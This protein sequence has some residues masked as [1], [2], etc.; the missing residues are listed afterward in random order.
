MVWIVVGAL[1]ADLM[2]QTFPE[3]SACLDAGNQTQF[4]LNMCSARGARISD[5][6]RTMAEDRIGW[7]GDELL[8]DASVAKWLAYRKAACDLEGAAWEGGSGQPMVIHGCLGSLNL[9]RAAVI[10]ALLE[11]RSKAPRS[12]ADADAALNA[13]WKKVGVGNPAMLTVQR[14]WLA[15]RDAECAWEE[16]RKAGTKDRCLAILTDTR[17]IALENTHEP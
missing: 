1:A 17:A 4:A 7:T 11:D 8:F 15:Y 2:Q 9:E 5:A 6:R 12:L 13:A 3:L 14:A 10:E 16:S